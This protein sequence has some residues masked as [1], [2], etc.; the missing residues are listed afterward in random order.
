MNNPQ[1][2]R[3]FASVVHVVLVILMLAGIVM[4]GQQFS[5]AIYQ[6]GLIVLTASTIV[7]I[8]FGNIPGNFN[9]RRSMRFFWPF[10]GVI[11]IVFVVSF[12]LTPILYALGR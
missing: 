5:K 1:S 11:L 2:K 4:I 10:M 6:L 3:P 7:Q 9:F 12:L 8:A